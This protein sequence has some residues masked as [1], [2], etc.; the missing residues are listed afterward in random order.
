MKYKPLI[1]KWEKIAFPKMKR[2]NHM[3]KL[4]NVILG[5]ERKKVRKGGVLKVEEKGT[6]EK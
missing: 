3:K 4:P 2:N 5:W 1:P 6:W